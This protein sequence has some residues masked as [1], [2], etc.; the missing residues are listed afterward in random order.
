MHIVLNSRLFRV[1][2]NVCL[3]EISQ[4]FTKNRAWKQYEM[5]FPG[6]LGVM[7]PPFH[8][9]GHVVPN[10]QALHCG[11]KTK[12]NAVGLGI[13]YQVVNTDSSM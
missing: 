3:E 12:Q 10:P 13:I 2:S 8:R 4:G 1:L 7:A 6:N 9:S 5:E 11:Q